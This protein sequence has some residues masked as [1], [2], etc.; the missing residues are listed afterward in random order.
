LE[1]TSLGGYKDVIRGELGAALTCFDIHEIGNFEQL[2]DLHYTL[3]HNEP[4]SVQYARYSFATILPLFLLM[5][6]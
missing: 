2:L 6:I 1:Q 5:L 4:R 3:F